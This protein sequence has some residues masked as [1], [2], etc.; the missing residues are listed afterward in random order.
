[1]A[2]ACTMRQI[3]AANAAFAASSA[4]SSLV[5]VFVGATA[6]IGE[7]SL[8]AFHGSTTSSKIYF[9]GRSQASGDQILSELRELHPD[10]KNTI[11]FISADLTSLRNVDK[12]TEEI[13]KS[14]EKVNLLFMS[15]G[16]LSMA[17]RDET[18]EGLDKKLT[19]HYY[20]RMRF[21]LSLLP[22]LNSASATSTSPGARVISVLSPGREIKL[23]TDDMELAK[24]GNYTLRAA[25]GHAV[26]FN[27]LAFE[28]LAQQYPD[29]SFIHDY[30][31]VVLTS[32]TRG[33]PLPARVLSYGLRPALKLFSV[34]LE[35]CGQGHLRLAT[36]DEFRRGF[37]LVDWKGKSMDTREK[38]GWWSE[39]A[40]GRVWEHTMEVMERIK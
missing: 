2:A 1:M 25:E 34:P 37:W 13:K 12:V 22:L 4:S 35:D 21:V 36:A 38:G 9:V 33:L 16:F 31:S 10:S 15:P 26:A 7:T 39:E 5:A 28:T 40:R 23:N 6:G 18:S 27:S 3:R 29:I 11:K 32:L 30:P 14:E 20:A 24:P 19:I 8:K 17:G